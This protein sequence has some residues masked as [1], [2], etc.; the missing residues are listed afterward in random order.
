MRFLRGRW[1]A[2]TAAAVVTPFLLLAG[3]KSG[4]NMIALPKMP[5]MSW[6]KKK[7]DTDLAKKGDLTPPS[8]TALANQGGEAPR[9]A[10]R[11]YPNTQLPAARPGMGTPSSYGP[12][13][14]YASATSTPGGQAPYRQ[15]DYYSPSP[16]EAGTGRSGGF[17]DPYRPN[18]ERTATLPD[19]APSAGGYGTY[20]SP[21]GDSY[22]PAPSRSPYQGSSMPHDG[23]LNGGVPGSTPGGSMPSYND[24]SYPRPATFE[25]KM[26]ATSRDGGV[27]NRGDS[28]RSGGGGASEG[29]IRLAR[30]GPI[31]D[32]GAS[33][34]PGATCSGDSCSLPASTSPDRFDSANGAAWRPGGTSDF[35]ANRWSSDAT[36][37]A[38]RPPSSGYRDPPAA[39]AS[40]Q[41][42]GGDYPYSG[43]PPARD[44]GFGGTSTYR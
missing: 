17:Q 30:G 22:S 37:T 6:S 40:E 4:T 34:V 32:R 33:A 35:D 27:S 3:C 44:S 20:G 39:M 1:T 16:A 29:A 31:D 19:G 7:S 10:D 21:Y 2:V 26:G 41:P 28:G 42:A 13:A 23:G 9:Y 15:P 18:Y 12:G 25:S 8:Q 11:S 14:S 5:S 43:S 24:G 36:R 38:T